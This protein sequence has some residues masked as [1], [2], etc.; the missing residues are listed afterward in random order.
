MTGGRRLGRRR[1]GNGHT[2]AEVNFSVWE[3]DPTL[4]T[5]KI[6]PDGGP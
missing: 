1:D 3:P 5:L 4:Y 2:I 6:S